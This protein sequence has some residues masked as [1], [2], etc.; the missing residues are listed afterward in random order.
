MSSSILLVL[1][2]LVRAIQ[3]TFGETLLEGVDSYPVVRQRGRSAVLRQA[4]REFLG[5][6]ET[7]EIDRRYAMGYGDSDSIQ[8]ELGEW[9]REG[10]WPEDRSEVPG[11]GKSGNADFASPTKGDR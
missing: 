1:G 2:V 10:V 3:A 9:D 5:R 7:E 6:L 4:A 11:E 8:T